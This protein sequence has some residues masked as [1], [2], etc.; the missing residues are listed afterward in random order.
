MK[1]LRNE[2]RKKII[3][4]LAAVKRFPHQF[5][6]QIDEMEKELLWRKDNPEK[7]PAWGFGS[8][9]KNFW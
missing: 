2:P 6:D 8:A 9:G 3:E 1:D 4:M 5:G 7:E